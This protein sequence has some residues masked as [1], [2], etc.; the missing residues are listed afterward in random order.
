MF[1]TLAIKMLENNS[2]ASINVSFN[3]DY[4]KILKCPPL[5]FMSLIFTQL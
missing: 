1:E 4:G 5:S 2:S 3:F